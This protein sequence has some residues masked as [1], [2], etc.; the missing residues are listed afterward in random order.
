MKQAKPTREDIEAFEILYRQFNSIINGYFP[1]EKDG[2]YTERDEETDDP[3]EMDTDC[4]DHCYTALH[5]I[6]SLLESRPAML[7]RIFGTISAVFYNDVFDPA[8][9]YLDWHP[10]LV[11]A[12]EAREARKKAAE[13][14]VEKEGEAH[15][16]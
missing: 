8:K 1:P 16:C 10:D 13:V 12:I 7:P 6:L 14:E 11:P 3:V 9:D 4:E 2:I 5:R 15:A